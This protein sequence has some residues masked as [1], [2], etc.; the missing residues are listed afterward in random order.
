M[1]VEARGAENFCEGFSLPTISK[2]QPERCEGVTNKT[3]QDFT[4]YS[5][6][7][8]VKTEKSSLL[9]CVD[10]PMVCLVVC[11]GV[12][13]LFAYVYFFCNLRSDR[14]FYCLVGSICLLA[15]SAAVALI[16]WKKDS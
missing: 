16:D 6:F 3:R 14:V 8:A 5:I 4:T 15:T 1:V 13:V 2:N 9:A 11:F 10:M 12:A 7:N